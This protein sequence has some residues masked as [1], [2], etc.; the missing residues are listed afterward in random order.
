MNPG[1]ILKNMFYLLLKRELHFEFDRIPL[2]A[3]RISNKKLK[4]LFKIGVN[5]IFRISKP[6]GFPYMAHISP[7]GLCNLKCTICPTWFPETKGK[8]LL[9]FE[10][11]KKFIDEVGEYLLYLI[12]WSWG[13]PFLNP[14]IYKMIKYAE[15]KNILTV[16]SSNLTRLT[17]EDAARLVRSGLDALIVAVD[18]ITQETYSRYRQGGN[19]SSVIGNT[20]MI[21]KEREQAGTAKPLV[22]LRMVISKENEHEVGAFKRLAQEIG[23]D[24]V[25]FKTFSTRQMGYE[26]P[27]VD[28]QYAP[29][30]RKFRW[31]RYLDGFKA[32]RRLKKYDC[33]FPW[34]KP[35]LFADGMILSCEFDFYYTHPFGNINNKSF[36]EIWFGDSAMRFR[37]E[38]L[39]NRDSIRF[40]RDCVYDY[41]L[42][43]G[44]VVEWEVLRKKP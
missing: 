32:D 7:S 27:S 31:Y 16:T 42:I 2:R 15:E 10:T 14:E 38:F 25:S 1:F 23:V 3:R 5:R 34:T 35:T 12:L 18:G 37:K 29:D 43:P 44:C 36:R 24:M 8:T 30:T 39:K 26:D 20:K 4:N 41:T 13:E 22:N 17:R 6:L 9:T 11:F 40:C 28:S 21:L 33:K 19:L